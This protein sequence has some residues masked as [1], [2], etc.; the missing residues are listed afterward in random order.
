MITVGREGEKMQPERDEKEAGG[1]QSASI[2]ADH[3]VVEDE[4]AIGRWE[5]V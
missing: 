4:P 3:G 1:E 5:L 2:D